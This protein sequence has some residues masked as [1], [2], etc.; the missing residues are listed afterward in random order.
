MF[1]VL[2][3]KCLTE[4]LAVA[5]NIYPVSSVSVGCYRCEFK[6][7]ASD[8]MYDVIVKHQRY[9]AYCYKTPAGSVDSQSF[10]CYSLTQRLP[11]F[12]SCISWNTSSDDEKSKAILLAAAG[13]I[14]TKEGH[15]VMC[16][17]CS[18][19]F[20]GAVR[21]YLSMAHLMGSE[22]FLCIFP[23]VPEYRDFNRDYR[24]TV[25][26]LFI[27]L[28]KRCNLERLCEGFVGDEQCSTSTRST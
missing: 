24:L 8:H 20:N 12:E 14:P 2:N 28:K 1:E 15:G 26:K 4:L 9:R 27:D 11:V 19:A 10:L 7:L 23:P 21:S 5:L 16:S 17:G 22:H 18:G 3:E 6:T 13:F 25:D